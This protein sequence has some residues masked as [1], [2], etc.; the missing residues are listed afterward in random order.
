[1]EDFPISGLKNLRSVKDLVSVPEINEGANDNKKDGI[2]KT[3]LDLYTELRK[4]H[5][6]D[7]DKSTIDYYIHNLQ[8]WSREDLI[9]YV[10]YPESKKELINNPSLAAALF[11]LLQEDSE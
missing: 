5:L 9:A 2:P 1:M 3:F 7:L 6:N 4:T 11:E 10:N 8:D